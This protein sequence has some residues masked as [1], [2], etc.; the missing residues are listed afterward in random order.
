MLQV[1]AQTKSLTTSRDHTAKEFTVSC[2]T[3][4]YMIPMA[5]H[6][7][8]CYT[9]IMPVNSRESHGLLVWSCCHCR[10]TRPDV[11]VYTT[12]QSWENSTQMNEVRPQRWNWE[13]Y[14]MII[15]PSLLDMLTYWRKRNTFVPRQI[16]EVWMPEIKSADAFWLLVCFQEI[17]RIIIFLVETK[18]VFYRVSVQR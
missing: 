9:D 6:L 8:N 12:G 2:W 5:T 7:S 11:C 4:V 18:I 1:L 14:P 17:N 15:L 16:Y 10:Q 3:Q 13:Q